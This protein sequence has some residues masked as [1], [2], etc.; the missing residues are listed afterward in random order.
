MRLAVTTSA[1]AHLRQNSFAD[2]RGWYVVDRMLRGKG[3]RARGRLII[4]TLTHH[5]DFAVGLYRASRSA[6]RLGEA[7]HIT[8]D[9]WLSWD[10]IFRI[11][12]R[13]AGVEPKTVHVPSE[14]IARF[15]PNWGPAF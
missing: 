9:E 11:V 1:L 8:G 6:V 14:V 4:W 15:D 3:H 7:F 2:G 12:G 13:A 5:R 10:E